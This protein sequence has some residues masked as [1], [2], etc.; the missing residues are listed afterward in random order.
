M[1]GSTDQL[2]DKAL[3]IFAFAAYHELISGQPVSSVVRRDHAGHTA[4]P[5]GVAE[6]ENRDLIT[7]EEDVLHL[8]SEMKEF[9]H[10]LIAAIRSKACR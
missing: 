8:N 5:D 6:L 7:V 10:M 4:D 3:S 9:L 2:S 1:T